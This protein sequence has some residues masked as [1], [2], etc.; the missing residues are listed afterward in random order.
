MK[1]G[2]QFGFDDGFKNGVRRIYQEAK[3]KGLDVNLLTPALNLYL[4][5]S[6]KR[7]GIQQYI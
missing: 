1:E 4:S 2:W 5:Q 7:Q 3:D 6:E